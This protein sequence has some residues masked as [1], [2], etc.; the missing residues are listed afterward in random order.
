MENGQKTSEAEN[1]ISFVRGLCEAQ[2]ASSEARGTEYK[3]VT[4]GETDDSET[5]LGKCFSKTV[6]DIKK[7]ISH[8]QHASK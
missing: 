4:E 3:E 8:K 5:N 6:I 1:K 2:P 7:Q